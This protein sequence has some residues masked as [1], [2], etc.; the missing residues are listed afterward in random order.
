M[1]CQGVM[2]CPAFMH[3][4]KAPIEPAICRRPE[5]G[6]ANILTQ[7]QKRTCK[8]LYVPPS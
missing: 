5:P 2:V 1:G 3:R 6:P 4:S 8:G 7:C